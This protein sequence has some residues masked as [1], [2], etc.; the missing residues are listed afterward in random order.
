[1]ADGYT[2]GRQ[3]GAILGFVTDRWQLL[4]GGSPSERAVGL[5]TCSARS[6]AG[7]TAVSLITHNRRP[8]PV[9]SRVGVR[10]FRRPD[11]RV[12]SLVAAR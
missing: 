10:R 12:L 9:A 2:L 7:L 8:V 3:R 11:H 5:V 4:V 1:M 6:C